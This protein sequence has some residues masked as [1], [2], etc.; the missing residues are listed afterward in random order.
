MADITPTAILGFRIIRD[1]I[2]DWS[3]SLGRLRFILIFATLGLQ[4]FND[5]FTLL[6]KDQQSFI[7]IPNPARKSSCMWNN[8][9][10]ELIDVRFKLHP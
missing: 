5:I 8:V 10:D 1:G 4:I 9:F 3:F 6:L 2:W 7:L